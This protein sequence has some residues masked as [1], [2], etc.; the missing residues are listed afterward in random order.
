M[1]VLEPENRLTINEI[2]LHPWF[3]DE[4]ILENDV[5]LPISIPL[6]TK[7]SL[8]KRKLKHSFNL[9]RKAI[10][11]AKRRISDVE[12]PQSPVKSKRHC[13]RSD[14][15][16]S[17]PPSVKKAEAGNPQAPIERKNVERPPKRPAAIYDSPVENKRACVHLD[18]DLENDKIAAQRVLRSIKDS[19]DNRTNG[20]PQASASKHN[21]FYKIA[22]PQELKRPAE[23]LLTP[24]IVEIS[25][26]RIR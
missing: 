5:E 9:I 12:L 6:L 26:K 18:L 14:T 8:R 11:S 16:V 19:I 3:D 20:P 13:L 1:L 2:L 17:S 24:L 15:V 22:I 4:M 21:N 10:R 23:Q 7:P 25:K